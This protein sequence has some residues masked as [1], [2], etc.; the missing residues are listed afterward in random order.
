VPVIAAHPRRGFTLV[1]LLV[2]LSLAAVV[3]AALLAVLVRQQRFYAGVAQ[4]VETRGHVRE[5]LGVLP[6][7][8][9]G[10]S[11]AAGDLLAMSDSAIELRATVGSAVACDA[12]PHTLDLP[13]LDLAGITLTAWVS[14]PQ[15]GDEVHVL[16]DRTGEFRSFAVT[17]VESASAW[18]PG[19]PFTNATLDAGKARHRVT[20]AAPL[21][22]G[23]GSGSPMRF[24]RRVR[25]SLYRSPSDGQWYLGYTEMNPSTRA[26][27]AIQPVSGPYRPHAGDGTSGVA[28][29]F[30][31][32]SGGAVAGAATG[33][34]AAIDVVVRAITRG[35]VR[36][37][38]MRPNSG[39]RHADA[40]SISVA[41]RNRW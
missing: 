18:C 2:A 28:F 32:A 8:L 34:V 37:E 40:E 11:S 5:G 36:I 21:P 13:P 35:I 30:L 1:E 33:Q 12:G 31:D 9:R 10:L 15:S 6:N 3:T 38:G 23:V 4:L 39:L 7:D 19:P 14:R 25:Y 29:R 26:F 24:T 17:A 16:D 27:N 20:V 41:I 22:P